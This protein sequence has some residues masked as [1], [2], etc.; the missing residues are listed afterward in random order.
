MRSA[1]AAVTCRSVRLGTFGTPWP[2]LHPERVP[3]TGIF[4]VVRIRFTEPDD[5]KIIELLTKTL[6]L[7]AKRREGFILGRSSKEVSRIS[8]EGPRLSRDRGQNSPD[9]DFR[10]QC[11]H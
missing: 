6:Q 10:L 2:T 4:S 7:R 8:P 11:G 1:V 3:P 5:A 9:D